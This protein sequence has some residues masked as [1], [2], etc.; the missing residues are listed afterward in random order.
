MIIG[1]AND[2]RGAFDHASCVPQ[3]GLVTITC[4]DEVPYE[5]RNRLANAS[6]ELLS[7]N[8]VMACVN[9]DSL[10][11]STCFYISGV[12]DYSQTLELPP[13]TVLNKTTVHYTA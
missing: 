1:Y 13:I 10:F 2:E 5:Y 7:C 8:S 9:K 12:Q 11:V 4:V 6:I 3:L